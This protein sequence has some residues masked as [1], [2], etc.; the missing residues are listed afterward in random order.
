[1][2]SCCEVTRLVSEAQE[3]PLGLQ[4]RMS[5]RMHTTLCSACRKF[6]DQLSTIRTAM[7][8][9]AQSDLPADQ[10]RGPDR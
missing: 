3:R 2:L 4:E 7:R 6:E 10:D 9:L 1:M 5:L 8:N